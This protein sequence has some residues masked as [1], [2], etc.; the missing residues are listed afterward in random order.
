MPNNEPEVIV[1]PERPF[2]KPKFLIPLGLGVLIVLFI[3]GLVSQGRL[4][5]KPEPSPAPQGLS[6]IFVC[7]TIKEFCEN[8]Q[9]IIRNGNY[10]GF[11]AKIASGS[12]IYA[13]FDGKITSQARTYEEG[14]IITSLFLHNSETN[15]TA[16]Y[17]F[18]GEGKSIDS[19]KAGQVIGQVGNQMDRFSRVNLLFSLVKYSDDQ[20]AEVIQF[21][22]QLR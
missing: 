11:G 6:P 20:Q 5:L 21:P 9:D 4:K 14:D 19:V 1:K 22:Q 3:V 18:I 13:V 17:R 2:L 7:P 16:A 12:A 15:T 8:G 10:V